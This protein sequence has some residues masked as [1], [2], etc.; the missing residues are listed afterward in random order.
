MKGA[1]RSR[2]QIHL[3]GR[4]LK[5]NEKERR[6]K[7]RVARGMKTARRPTGFSRNFLS[8]SGEIFSNRGKKVRYRPD[9]YRSNFNKKKKI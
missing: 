6:Q 8:F 3:S 1:A 9:N 2:T 7:E 4:I 5:N